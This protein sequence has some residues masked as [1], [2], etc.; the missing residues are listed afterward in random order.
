MRWRTNYFSFDPFPTDLH[1]CSVD[2]PTYSVISIL[3]PNLSI[4][5]LF[6][7]PHNYASHINIR[8]KRLQYTMVWFLFGVLFKSYL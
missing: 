2:F 7:D 5:P 6:A 1:I 3:Y 8:Y 4:V